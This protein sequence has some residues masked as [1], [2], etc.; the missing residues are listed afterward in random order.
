[1]K[2]IKISKV[3]IL[4]NV[5]MLLLVNAYSQPQKSILVDEHKPQKN[6]GSGNFFPRI[7][8]LNS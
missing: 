6:F 3:L 4:I 8:S 5:T 7:I 1:M 2:K